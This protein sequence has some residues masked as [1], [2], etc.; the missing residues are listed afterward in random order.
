MQ[1]EEFRYELPDSAIAQNPVEPRDSARLLDTRDGTDHRFADL[2]AL[3]EPGDLVVVNTTRVRHARLVGRRSGTG[4]KIELL[5]LTKRQTGGWSALAA[6]SRRLRPGAALEFGP[7]TATVIDGPVDG[8]VGVEFSDEGL[9]DVVGTV[10]LPPYITGGLSDPERYQ[11]IFADNPGSAAAPTAG[12]HFT[13]RV[14]DGL[15]AR[16]IDLATVELDVGI[17]TFR[18][19]TTDR[20][21][22][23]V[24]HRERCLIPQ[25]TADAIT[26]AR[27][28]SGRVVAIGTT[29]VRTLETFARNDG[30]VETGETDTDLFLR[31]GSTF[32]VVDALVTNFH[33][34]GSSLLVML[35][36]FMGEGWRD[37]YATALDRGYRFLSFGDAMLAERQR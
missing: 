2:A 11:T 16:G 8:M 26:A 34:P 27:A 24:M 33:V 29:T 13:P 4:G 21:E 15:A 9:L 12:L 30:T 32:R 25:A 23:H 31:P 37:S 7:V 10:P 36:A 6:P 5:L 35:A 28:R 17:G 1:V 22:D 18:P 14:L 19:I 20:V 3:L